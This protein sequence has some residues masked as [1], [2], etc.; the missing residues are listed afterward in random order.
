MVQIT[1][2]GSWTCSPAARPFRTWIRTAPGSVGVHLA[3]GR[4]VVRRA[5]SGT[6]E[7]GSLVVPDTAM[8]ALD[9]RGLVM[10]R[11]MGSRLDLLGMSGAPLKTTEL[12]PGVVVKDVE[13]RADGE[14][15]W[16]FGTVGETFHAQA[17]DRALVPSG[18]YDLTLAQGPYPTSIHVHP[19]ADAF[20][21]TT[22][23]DHRDPDATIHRIAASV[24]G[25]VLR[26]LWDKDEIDHPCV[27]FTRDGRA[28][29]GVDAF[30][31]V[32]LFA[33]SDHA[34]VGEAPLPEGYESRFDGEIVGEH[35]LTERHPE[36]EPASS[37]MVHALPSLAEEA[38]IDWAARG[39]FGTPDDDAGMDL[40]PALGSECFL[41][42]KEDAGAAAWTLRV[43][44]LV[45]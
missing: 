40:G 13:F 9:P 36:G 39:E 29:V 26:V 17:F 19:N 41:E 22:N 42:V 32:S 6:P 4:F 18:A 45:P 38:R 20:L 21:L 28:L 2:V 34:R 31:G 30:C 1:L 11:V 25:G 10:V 33:W 23:E 35:L 16:V 8:I 5:A 44:R 7:V 14:R 43:W 37:M 24:A 3:D 15:L 27:G 12:T